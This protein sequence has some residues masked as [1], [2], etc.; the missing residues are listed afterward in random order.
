MEKR[1]T[2]PWVRNLGL[3]MLFFITTALMILPLLKAH[4]M[5]IVSDWTFHASRVEEIFR[6]LQAGEWYTAIATHTFQGTGVASWLFYPTPMLYIWAGLRFIFAPITAF[7]IW[8]GMFIFIGFLIDYWCMMRVVNNPWQ[9]VLFAYAYSLLP[10][11]ILLGLNVY[12]L[13]EFIATLFIPLVFASFYGILRNQPKAW[14]ALSAGMALVVYTHLLTAIIAVE[15]MGVIMI[16]RVIWQRHFVKLE[17]LRLLQSGVMSLILVLP[18]LIPFVSDFIG[19]NIATA[20]PGITMLANFDDVIKSSI[21]NRMQP[22]IGLAL[23]LVIVFSFKLK[24]TPT[25]YRLCALMGTIL[26]IIST[27]LVPWHLLQSTP[28]AIIQMPY[29]YLSFAGLFL[30]V[31][32]S[33][34]IYDWSNSHG[35]PL[36]P[37]V[38]MSIIVVVLIIFNFGA[39]SD[40]ITGNTAG[41]RLPNL[42]R[43]KTTKVIP[44][45]ALITNHNYSNQFTY[46]VKYGEIDYYPKVSQGNAQ[47]IVNNVTYI[48]NR[49]KHLIKH[50]GPNKISYHVNLKSDK[51]VNLPVLKYTR[52]TLNVDGYYIKPQTS[53]RGTVQAKISAGKHTITVG[54]QKS[55]LL[56]PSIIVA[57]IAWVCLGYFT[58]ANKIKR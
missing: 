56:I 20:A 12:T 51:I 33:K 54:Y 2:N 27:S 14:I 18:I 29:R 55:P 16:V 36:Q 11:R 6:N 50:I 17:W 43:A 52:T 35:M 37:N 1:F 45:Q 3:I 24:K 58:F 21:G 38:M 49:A 4:Q 30:A 26:L 47:N 46:Q 34:L 22:G 41:N 7:Y 13:A 42:G 28:L 39:L 9:S 10:Y 15:I 5:I 8:I 25:I 48:N 31:S 32:F 44:D 40:T 53:W 57:I 19:K 23:L